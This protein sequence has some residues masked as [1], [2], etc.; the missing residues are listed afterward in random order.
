MLAQSEYC[1][2]EKI[3]RQE[4]VK[5]CYEEI[6]KKHQCISMK[7]LAVSGKDLIQAGYRPGP[8][9]GEILNR[10]LDHVLEIPEDNTKEKL[11][12]LI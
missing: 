8:E 11:M 2:E 3:R 5:A 1:R 4:S 9:L 6:L 12:S 10:L 7:M